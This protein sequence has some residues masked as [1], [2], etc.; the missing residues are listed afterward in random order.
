MRTEVAIIGAGPAGLLLSHL[1]AEQGVESVIVETRSQEYVL[2]RIRAGILEHS[3]VQLLDDIGLGARLHAE[4]QEHRGIY[5]QWPEERHHIDFTDLVGRSVWVYG[6]TEVT[7]DLVAAREAAGQQIYYEVSDTALHDV[8]SDS[9]YVTFTDA[10][11]A[12]VRVD[13]AVIA[14]C[15]GSFGPS[16]ATVPGRVRQTWERTYPYSWLGVLADVAPS[17]DELIYAWHHDGFAMHS[18]RSDTVSRLYLQVP[19]GTDVNTWSD[20]RIWDSLA[21]R[22]GH[23]QN[24]WELTPG[25]IT[26][27][28]VLPMRSYVQTPM[29]HGN[30]FLAGDAAHIVP[31]TGAKGLNLAVA[32]VALLA[33]ALVALVRRNNEEAAAEYSD[34][35]LRRVWRCTH[36]SWWMTTMLH[37]SADAFDAQLQLSQLRWVASSE[38]GATG[39]AENYAGLPIGF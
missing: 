18:M 31:P 21:A 7:K 27:K 1:L 4:G 2:S 38:A 14:G 11:G 30:L 20:D 5:L 25:P 8:E 29:R 13:A 36:F 24:G 3:T 15:D 10:S 28:S 9:P 32:D 17:T 22:L 19:N 33:P 39:L 12:E 16:R 34:N 37:T 26:E 35:A 6:Q 23:G